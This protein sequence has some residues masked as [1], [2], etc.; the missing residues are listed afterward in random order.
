MYVST[1]TYHNSFF[2]SIK[3]ANIYQVSPR[4]SGPRISI[5]RIIL[6]CLIHN[7]R[8][9]LYGIKITGQMLYEVLEFAKGWKRNAKSNITRVRSEPFMQLIKI[10]PCKRISRMPRYS[11]FLS[12]IMM[13]CHQRSCLGGH[14]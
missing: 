2:S 13:S 14:I 5:E 10:F 7:S 1:A 4:L 12:F 8:C 9:K 11:I 3:V 6:D